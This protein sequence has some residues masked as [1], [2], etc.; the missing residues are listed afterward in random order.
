MAD[1]AVVGDAGLAVWVFGFFWNV[2][3]VKVEFQLPWAVVL[4][5]SHFGR[6]F[7][8]QHLRVDWRNVI[9]I[10]RLVGDV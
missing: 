5:F 8:S 7:L 6:C 1:R 9:M 4:A 2:F 10:E 3:M